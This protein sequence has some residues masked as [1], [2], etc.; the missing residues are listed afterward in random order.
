MHSLEASVYSIKEEEEFHSL[1]S[2]RN[3]TTMGKPLF[4]TISP[5]NEKDPHKGYY[6]KSLGQ[7]PSNQPGQTNSL[8]LGNAKI[9]NQSIKHNFGK[10]QQL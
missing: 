8:Y 9:L 4:P 2:N 5:K 6:Q 10:T 3:Y 1:D 7:L